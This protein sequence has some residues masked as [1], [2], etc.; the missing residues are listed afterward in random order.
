MNHSLLTV[1]AIF[2]V[3]FTFSNFAFAADGAG[4]E[5]AI[6]KSAKDFTD[7]YDHADAAA[8]AAQWTKDGEYS[9]GRDTVKGRDAIAKLYTGFFKVHAGSK[10]TVKIDSIRVLAPTVALEKGTASV[11]ES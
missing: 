1:V 6:R 10:M 5:D 8:I 2:L 3:A 9:I 4:A 11:S 7:A